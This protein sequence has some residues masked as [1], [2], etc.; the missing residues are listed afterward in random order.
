MEHHVDKEKKQHKND[1]RQ[2]DLNKAQKTNIWWFSDTQPPYTN[3]WPILSTLIPNSV[4]NIR[5]VMMTIIPTS[6]H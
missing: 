1:K 3:L 5:H 4:Q 2:V 6:N